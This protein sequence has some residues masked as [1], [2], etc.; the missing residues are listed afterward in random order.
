[1]GVRA[2]LR[3]ALVRIPAAVGGLAKAAYLFSPIKIAAFYAL[4][5]AQA[6]AH[7]ASETALY[8]AAVF[9]FGK[10]RARVLLALLVLSPG[11]LRAAGELLPSSF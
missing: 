9:C 5:C 10:E 7:A 1:M 2:A 4:R 6:L 11:T 3:A 8:D